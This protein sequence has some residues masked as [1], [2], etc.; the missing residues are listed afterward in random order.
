MIDAGT[1]AAAAESIP[2]V[3]SGVVTAASGSAEPMTAVASAAASAASVAPEVVTVT[4]PSGMGASVLWAAAIAA[5]L[6]GALDLLQSKTKLLDVSTKKK[7]LLISVAMTA[8]VF[9]LDNVALGLG[10]WE[11]IVMAGGPLGAVVADFIHRAVSGKSKDSGLVFQAGDKV[12]VDGTRTLDGQMAD[13]LGRG[14]DAK[15]DPEPS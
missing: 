10:L 5:V 6:K 1:A 3:A 13:L 11:S 7:I 8:G 9:V 12:V 14:K 2:A 4:L 15:P